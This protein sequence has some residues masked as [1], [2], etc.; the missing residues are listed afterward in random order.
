METLILFSVF[1]SSIVCAHLLALRGRYL[2]ILCF[3]V[4]AALLYSVIYWYVGTLEGWDGLALAIFSLIAVMPCGA[5]LILGAGSG[6]FH[7]RIRTRRA[8]K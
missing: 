6:W 7:Q 1:F 2:Q 8:A 4:A 3:V 5:G